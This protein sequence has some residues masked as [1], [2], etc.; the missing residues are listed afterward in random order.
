MSESSLSPDPSCCFVFDRPLRYHACLIQDILPPSDKPQPTRPIFQNQD[1]ILQNLS[2]FTPIRIP[3]HG[4]DRQT[5]SH[6]RRFPDLLTYDAVPHR[7][8]LLLELLVCFAI[9]MELPDRDFFASKHLEDNPRGIALHYLAASHLKVEN[10]TR[11]NAHT[12][13]GSVCF[14]SSAQIT[15]LLMYAVSDGSQ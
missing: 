2:N 6:N 10:G 4:F 14:F 8:E 11:M 7:H 15:R 3:K 9:A 1:G 13:T 12:D 5:L